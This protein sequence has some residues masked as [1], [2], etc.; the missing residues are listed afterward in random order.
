MPKN[1]PEA[2]RKIHDLYVVQRQSL[3]NVKRL[4]EET[5]GF[6]ASTRTYRGY[7]K[8]WGYL[9][10]TAS[11]QATGRPEL[12][13]GEEGIEGLASVSGTGHATDAVSRTA[14]NVEY[15]SRDFPIPVTDSGA[16]SQGAEMWTP[17]PLQ[18]DIFQGA[19]SLSYASY[20]LTNVGS[21]LMANQRPHIL[22]SA[23][24]HGRA[25]LQAA[26]NKSMKDIEKCL[27]TGADINVADH[28]GNRPLHYA[29]KRGFADVIRVLLKHRADPDAENLA[30]ETPLHLCV[31]FPK[32]MKELLKSY[33]MVSHQDNKGDTPLHLAV[34]SSRLRAP[35]KG[36]TVELLIRAGADVNCLNNAHT[37]P[38]HLLLEEDCSKEEHHASF[39][40]MFLENSADIFLP[41]KTGKSSF[42]VFAENTHS[43]WTQYDPKPLSRNRNLDV[44]LF[45]KLFLAKCANIGIVLKSGQTLLNQ[46]L[47]DILNYGRDY[48]L[49]EI[50]YNNGDV[51]KPGLKGNCPLHVL[52]NQFYAP[53]YL[54]GIQVILSRGAN[55]NH[56]NQEG[57]SPLVISLKRANTK[58]SEL[59]LQGGADPMQRDL[60]GN[61]PIYLV[62]E[63]NTSEKKEFLKLL[64]DSRWL[65]N[66]TDR[67][68]NSEESIHRDTEWWDEYHRLV[69]QSAWSSPAHLVQ[70]TRLLPTK[71]S[72]TILGTALH[73][74]A[75]DFL[76]PAKTAFDNLKIAKGLHH[77]E[78]QNKSRQFRAILTDCRE[79]KI[80]VDQ[81]WYQMLLDHFLKFFFDSGLA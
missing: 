59:L 29:A 58:V 23:E 36:S 55:P 54:D 40:L 34:T 3:R 4:M 17:A 11:Q 51:M 25:L 43:R 32:A 26:K 35:P 74:L 67:R 63:S 53:R 68:T 9:R 45:V 70:I 31:Q 77:Q 20:P 41:T 57:E 37:T 81:S 61:L 27:S 30:Q 72:E 12:R 52:V 8:K 69:K 13:S 66:I 80:D 78:T 28:Q 44:K 15:G 56:I 38:F 1:W 65:P 33:P 14:S 2:Q 7:L 79:F 5:Y 48:E 19:T 18:G 60:A 6:K 22:G 46:C 16:I 62:V 49:G 71:V 10:Q 73:M 50:L 39:M 76:A 47:S 24:G 64:L 75:M 21:L 42:E